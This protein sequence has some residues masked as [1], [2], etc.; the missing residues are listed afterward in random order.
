MT[1]NIAF[2]KRAGIIDAAVA[3]PQRDVMRVLHAL[4]DDVGSW[5]L[6]GSRSIEIRDAKH[7]PLRIGIDGLNR[8]Q[9]RLL[10]I[11]GG[12]DLGRPAVAFVVFVGSDVAGGIGLVEKIASPVITVQRRVR[13]E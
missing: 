3:E 13:V 11:G 7:G 12:V 5:I 10:P 4:P 6:L 8:D 9:P 2:S 1:K